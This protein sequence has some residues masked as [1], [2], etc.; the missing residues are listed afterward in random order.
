[1]PK[2][3]K[4]ELMM[5]LTRILKSPVFQGRQIMLQI[6]E[7]KKDGEGQDSAYDAQTIQND[8][9]TTRNLLTSCSRDPN[10]TATIPRVFFS[11]CSRQL[12]RKGTALFEMSRMKPSC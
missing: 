5:H 6:S 4:S 10:L 8:P 11:F 3:R 9:I 12:I 2:V 1:M 7:K